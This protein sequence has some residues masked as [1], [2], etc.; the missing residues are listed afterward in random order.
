MILD[1]EKKYSIRS[2][3]DKVVMKILNDQMNQKFIP[4]K[5]RIKYAGMVFDKDD[6]YS[7]LDALLSSFSNNWFALGGN[8]KEFQQKLA[9]Y[10]SL[11]RTVFVNSGSS[12]NLISIATLAAKKRIK[13]GDE[14]ITIAT[15][16][17]TTINPI[18]IYGLKPVV[19]DVQ[20]PSYTANLDEL[21]K[22]I[23]SRT[24]LIM[25]PHINGSPHDM[26]R[27]LEIAKKHDL[28]VVED[29][30]DALGSRYGNKM[31]GTFGN[32]ATYSFYAA[33]HIST[34]EG[35]AVGGN[36]DNLLSTAESI[37]DWGR[38]NLKSISLGMR[39]LSL[40]N[41]STELPEDYEDRYTY[42]NMGYNLK[43]LDAQA[44][45]GLTQLEKLDKFGSLRRYNHKFLFE[46][47][48]SLTDQ[49][50]LPEGLPKADPSWFAFPITIKNNS[51]F[52]RLDIVKFLE[53]CN[54]ETRA[55]LAGDITKH[56]AYKDVKFR[57]IGKLPITKEILDNS[58]VIGVYPG[59]RKEEL[60]YMIDCFQKF[61]R[62]FN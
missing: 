60:E 58:F 47:L 53:D 40:Q 46:N 22:A 41:V 55:L 11:K 35:G 30:C 25:L 16:F 45:M 54:I 57:K 49:L 5:S 36:D 14:A 15:T 62:K 20:L 59:L 32:L 42:I 43:P 26:E 19:V 1:M 31:V 37:R 50:I 61:L 24:K 27:V 4:G 39:K 56:P 12:A 29:C 21:E 9:G 10:L 28:V 48:S 3:I 44:A 23:T 17:P 2:K 34:G 13:S 7:S 52:K 18:L 8:A 51:R 38:V 6:I 33:H